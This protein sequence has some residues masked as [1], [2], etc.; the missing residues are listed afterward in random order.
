MNEQQRTILAIASRLMSYPSESS[1]EEREHIDE[2]VDEN[3]ESADIRKHLRAALAPLDALSTRDIQEIYVSTFDL[4][5]KTGMYL[6]AHEFGD[7]PKRGAA[8]IKLQ[9]II[10]EAGFERTEG[11]LTDYI[12]MLFEFMAVSPED[13]HH[14]RLQRRLA[15]VGQRMLN[16]LEEENPYYPF[17]TLVMTEV[18]PKPTDEE[19]AQLERD[20]EEADLEELPY[21]I[22]YQ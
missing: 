11:E 7:S 19:V 21:P 12:P 1:A 2:A 9:K 15:N 17:F 10:N 5:S 8:M 18:F 20:R 22:M 16:H 6:T 3:I 14:E 4:K 13:A